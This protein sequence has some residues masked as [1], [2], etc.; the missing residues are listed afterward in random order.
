MQGKVRFSAA[1][2]L[3]S[4][5]LCSVWSVGAQN[6]FASANAF[7]RLARIQTEFSQPTVRQDPESLVSDSLPGRRCR[8]RPGCSL[9]RLNLQTKLDTTFVAFSDGK[10]G[11][12]VSGIDVILGY[13]SIDVYISPNCRPGTCGYEAVLAHE[14]EH[15]R[16]DRE[17]VQ[18]YAD[19]MQAALLSSR[20]ATYANPLPV[21]TRTEGR[22]RIKAQLST[23]LEPLF[24]ELQERRRRVSE[25]LD[26]AEGPQQIYKPCSQRQIRFQPR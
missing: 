1:P 4:L 18:E 24:E 17:L 25:G 19:K 7:G 5:I 10:K 14:K 26:E 8:N 21:D 13:R 23:L 2:I 20:W 12:W 11:F 6:H 3:L 16:L 22:E 9:M 15:I